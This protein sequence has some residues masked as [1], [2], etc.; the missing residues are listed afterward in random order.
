MNTI[1][2]RGE[3]VWGKI[4]GYPWWPAIIIDFSN[5]LVYTIKFYS[6]NSYAK[7]SSKFLLKY[8]E[9][10]NK[11]LEANKKNKKLLSA[12]KAADL[13][14][15]NLNNINYLPLDN[16]DNS[17]NIISSNNSKIKIDTEKIQIKKINNSI[18]KFEPKNFEKI[19]NNDLNNNLFNKSDTMSVQNN[20]VNIFSIVKNNK[21]T[22][23]INNQYSPIS[24]SRMEEENHIT[25]EKNN[26]NIDTNSNNNDIIINK[27]LLCLNNDDEI[28]LL[29]L[30]NNN[31][32]NKE[33]IK[34]E[35]EKTKKIKNIPKKEKKEEEIK[36]KEIKDKE[37]K[38]KEEY[39]IKIE[40][41]NL[42]TKTYKKKEIKT[43]TKIDDKIKEEKKKREEEDH[44]IYQI[45]EY[46]YKILE[47]YNNQKFDKLDYEKEHFKKVLIFLSKYK[48]DNFIEFL[49]MTNISKYIQYFV[50]YLKS[51]DIELNDLAKKVYR[52]FHKQFNKEYFSG[53]NIEI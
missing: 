38:E 44:F 35:N 39:Y 43:K 51:Y 15:K 11:I 22:N 52:N 50:C 17:Y 48:R 3:V 45:D 20:R 31:N 18:Q 1:F 14:L 4:K 23:T 10:K 24:S 16:I 36:E 12:I 53:N 26:S 30:N 46:F 5:N 2:E 25:S 32:K 42:D 34:K 47:L 49:K 6:D 8:E 21:S 41:E 19:N 13:D 33:V 27:N 37:I 7:L 28:N 29:L 40:I 9:N